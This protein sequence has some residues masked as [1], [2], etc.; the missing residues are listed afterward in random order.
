MDSRR[1]STKRDHAAGY[2]VLD[3]HLDMS[4]GAL[5]DE[6]HLLKSSIALQMSVCILHKTTNRIGMF[7][8]TYMSPASNGHGRSIHKDL[9]TYTQ[10]LH[11][12]C[13]KVTQQGLRLVLA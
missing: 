5:D 10:S 3:S 1:A 8:L 7:C 2:E 6:A 4:F 12:T 11:T 13:S 9:C